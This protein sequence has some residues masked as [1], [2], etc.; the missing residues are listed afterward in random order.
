MENG[1][2]YICSHFNQK[3]GTR[4]IFL[5]PFTVY[6]SC[7][8]TFVVFPFYDEYRISNIDDI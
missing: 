8:Q 2:I 6:S 7:K 1:T 5:N 4:K 3:T